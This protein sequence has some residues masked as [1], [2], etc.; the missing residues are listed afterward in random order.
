M[1]IDVCLTPEQIAA[2]P[3]F[4][5]SLKWF[6]TRCDKLERDIRE[7]TRHCIHEGAH[8]ARYRGLGAEV[9]FHGPHVQHDEDGKTEFIR[10]AVSPAS[11][12][13]T[14]D[15]QKAAVSMAGFV[16]LERLTGQ[17]ELEF[18]IESDL[19]T[20]KRKIKRSPHGT[21]EPADPEKRFER[22]KFLGEF[23]IL[24]DMEQPEFLRD[25]EKAVR[26]YEKDIFNTDETWNWAMKEFRFDIPGER[27]TV[28]L[29]CLGIWGVVIDDGNQLRLF[30]DGKEYSPH[31]KIYRSD[32]QIIQAST[33]IMPS[34][35]GV[36]AIVRRWNKEVLADE[37]QVSRIR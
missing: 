15:W 24:Q 18:A 25:L 36:E 4:A 7:K 20:L 32:L 28:G 26:D 33:S 12:V 3:D 2:E 21:Y 10:G 19:K 23:A 31:D 30:V 1:K 35:R 37:Y 9:R 29:Q 6:Q 27:Y 11:A 8:G 5:D 22:A 34:K 13:S 16:V 17:P 14:C